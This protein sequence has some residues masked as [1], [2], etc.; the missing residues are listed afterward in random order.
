MNQ[1]RGKTHRAAAFDNNDM[2]LVTFLK[3]AAAMLAK[4]GKED[5]AFYFTMVEDHLRSGGRLTSSPREM[6]KILGL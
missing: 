1:R 2:G 3:E 4:D 6:A 5:A